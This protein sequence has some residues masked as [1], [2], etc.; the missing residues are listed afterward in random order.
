MRKNK[1]HHK[2][3]KRKNPKSQSR[4]SD[5]IKEMVE[6]VSLPKISGRGE[7]PS[8]GQIATRPEFLKKGLG[9][10]FMDS[11]DKFIAENPDH[12]SIPT[13]RFISGIFVNTG[14]S[15]KRLFKKDDQLKQS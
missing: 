6:A 5:K 15:I 3:G 1:S 7:L 2:K 12:W 11:H 4:S 8:A 13:E 10:D 9:E 14:R